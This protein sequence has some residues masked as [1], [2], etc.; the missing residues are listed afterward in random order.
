MHGH[1]LMS[2]PCMYHTV[3]VEPENAVNCVC[4]CVC[5]HV[6]ESKF[7]ERHTCNH[8]SCGGSC[9]CL[10]SDHEWHSEQH[11]ICVATAHSQVT[12]W[13]IYNEEFPLMHQQ[14]T[15]EKKDERSGSVF[16]LALV[17]ERKL[18]CADLMF[19]KMSSVREFSKEFQIFDQGSDG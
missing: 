8:L 19:P 18:R 3:T 10:T 14:Q 16:C 6:Y 7:Q 5:V 17:W 4:V 2:C 13:V 1:S 9:D 11:R 12:G 15:A